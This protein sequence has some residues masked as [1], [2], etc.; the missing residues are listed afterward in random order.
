MEMGMSAVQFGLV[1][2]APG[3]LRRLSMAHDAAV[4]PT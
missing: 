4:T 1:R 3:K 2:H